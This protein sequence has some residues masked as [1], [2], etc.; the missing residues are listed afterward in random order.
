MEREYEAQ[1]SRQRQGG[2]GGT[3]SRAR[4]PMGQYSGQYDAAAAGGR[5]RDFLGYYK[6]LGLEEKEGESFC[7]KAEGRVAGCWPGASPLFPCC[8]AADRAGEVTTEEVK[9]AFKGRALVLHP[10]RAAATG[11]NASSPQRTT[12]CVHK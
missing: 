11:A 4:R 1:Y 12:A 6:V 3:R 8:A 7:G 2:S 9:A 10:D 5:R